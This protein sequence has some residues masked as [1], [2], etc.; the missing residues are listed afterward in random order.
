M[1]AIGDVFQVIDEQLMFGQTMLNV[2][3]YKVLSA[4]VTDNNA[5]S[6]ANAFETTVI[7]DVAACQSTDIVHV[8][9]HV[10]NLFDVS[11]KFDAAISVP[12]TAVMDS[13]GAFEAYPFRLVGNNGAVRN[14]AKRIAGVGTDAIT[15]GVV[16]DMGIL[17]SLGT[18]ATTMQSIL[19]WGLLAAEELAPV[20][21]KR[22]LEDGEYR[23]PETALEAVLSTIVDAIFNPVVTSQVSRKIGIGE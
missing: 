4:S 2:Y 11:D 6:V 20:I 9:I 10:Q 19:N 22:I 17:G 18:L 21:V 7:P 8:A 12:G 15:D 16:T 3:F 1:A 14:G 23:L 5:E 13:A